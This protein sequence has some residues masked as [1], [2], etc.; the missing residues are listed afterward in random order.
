MLLHR[1]RQGIASALENADRLD[2]AM[3]AASLVA[4]YL[5]AKGRVL[6]AYYLACATA[7]FAIGCAMQRVSTPVFGASSSP[8][9]LHPGAQRKGKERAPPS[10][11][12][13][14][15]AE[16]EEEESVLTS[17]TMPLLEPPHDPLELGQRIHTFWQLWAVDQLGAIATN[18]PPALADNVHDPLVRIDTCFPP[19]ITEFEPGQ[20]LGA[21]GWAAVN[22]GAVVGGWETL[23]SLYGDESG[24]GEMDV[25]GAG[26]G[27][28]VGVWPLGR[29]A[30]VVKSIELSSR[31]WKLSK[32]GTSTILPSFAPSSPMLNSPQLDGRLE[33]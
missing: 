22:G 26:G 19:E 13:S 24:S 17:S 7:R 27:P 28:T 9:T 23:R 4:M 16:E 3:Q 18:L 1:A 8:S 5:Y 29:T 12:Y 11:S 6:E 25:D 10:H 32:H 14:A 21:G 33:R 31:A 15:G 2:D 30:M 20:R